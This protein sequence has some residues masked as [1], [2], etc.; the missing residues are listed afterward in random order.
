MSRGAAGA[1][2]EGCGCRYSH[3][4]EERRAGVHRGADAGP[5]LGGG[6]ERPGGAALSQ[7]LGSSRPAGTSSP[8][9]KEGT[10]G[11]RGE[12]PG[13][14]TARPAA[15][16]AG[17]PPPRSA[18]PL[19]PRKAKPPRSPDGGGGR[20]RERQQPRAKPGRTPLPSRPRRYLPKRSERRARCGQGLG[21]PLRAGLRARSP[22]GL[23]PHPVPQFPHP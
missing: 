10:S 2:R 17:S 16:A 22:A 6:G 5:G 18:A 3:V 14:P 20:G 9:R 23:P 12:R 15:P 21:M 7:L 4:A 13:G 11:Y 1:G 19:P 8:Q